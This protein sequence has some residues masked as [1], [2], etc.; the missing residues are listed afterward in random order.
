MG[1]DISVVSVPSQG[2]AFTVRLPNQHSA[3]RAAHEAP[4]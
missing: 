1:G 3:L 4:F 2:S